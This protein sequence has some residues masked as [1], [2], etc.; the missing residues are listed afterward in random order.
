MRN[1]SHMKKLVQPDSHI[2]TP[3]EQDTGS[4]ITEASK[5]N[6]PAP[7]TVTVQVPTLPSRATEAPSLRAVCDRQPPSWMKDFVFL[8]S[9]MFLSLSRVNMFTF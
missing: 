2:D 8:S 5:E 4:P 1:T 3:E 9:H 7:L 6:E